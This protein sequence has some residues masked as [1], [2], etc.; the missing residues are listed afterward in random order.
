MKVYEVISP[1]YGGPVQVT[2]DDGV[3]VK[4]EVI[5]T[6]QIT[7]SLDKIRLSIRESDFMAEMSAWKMA[8]KEVDRAVTF[9]M[10][11]TRYNYKVDKALALQEW[12]KMS[13]ADQVAAYDFIPVYEAQLKLNGGLAK[14][15][16]VRYLK[17]KPWIQ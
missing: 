12:N 16:A 7:P 8:V 11:W 6:P 10:F 3:L 14:K 17:H 13:R 9:D 4:F 1:A 15:Y 5:T 2:F